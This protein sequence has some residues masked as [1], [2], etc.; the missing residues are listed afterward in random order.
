MPDPS[1]PGPGSYT[2]PSIVGKEANKHTLT[3]RI[4]DHLEIANTAFKNPGPGQYAPKLDF[5]KDGKYFFSKFKNS[6]ASTWNPPSS[7]RF[8]AKR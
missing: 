7:A 3:G 5:S 8:S 2:V 6:R 1:V 4:P